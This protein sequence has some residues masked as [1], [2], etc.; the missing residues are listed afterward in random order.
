MSSAGAA[1]QPFQDTTIERGRDA[2]LQPVTELDGRYSVPGA[3]ATPWADAERVLTDAEM[4]W[5]STVR[6]DGRPHVTPLIAVWLGEALYFSTGADEQKG[7]NLAANPACS[8]TTGNN[9]IGEGLDIVVEGMAVNIRDETTLQRVA[10]AYVAKY[11]SDWHFDVANGA[12]AHGESGVALVFEVAPVKAF[13]FRKGAYSQ[14]RWR[15]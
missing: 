5:I 12:F 4:F 14:T 3:T 7:R 1:G 9:A 8:L 13:G 2:R 15:F 6:G 10:D 11:G